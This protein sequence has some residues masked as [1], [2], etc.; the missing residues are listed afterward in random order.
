MVPV[1]PRLGYRFAWWPGQDGFK[2]CCGGLGQPVDALHAQ[3]VHEIAVV[4]DMFDG[5][6]SAARPVGQ[7]FEDLARYRAVEVDAGAL[8]AETT[9]LVQ[10]GARNR[11]SA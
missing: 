9:S 11:H 8:G 7:P 6:R 1:C 4:A 10:V 3:R 5:P 2:L